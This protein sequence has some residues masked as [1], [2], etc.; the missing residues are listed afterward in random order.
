VFKSG[1]S[2]LVGELS[3][4][5]EDE[6]A[7]AVLIQPAGRMQTGCAYVFRQEVEHSRTVAVILRCGEVAF[8]LVQHEIHS[9]RAGAGNVH[10]VDADGIDGR[11]DLLGIGCGGTAVHFNSA[12]VYEPH[13]GTP[14]AVA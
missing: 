11:V 12:V 9:A 14:R 10:A 3:V 13:Y 5:G 4:I 6:Q 1:V 7:G 8:R 2:E